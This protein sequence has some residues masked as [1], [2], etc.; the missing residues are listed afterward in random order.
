MKVAP[1]LLH[2]L[3]PQLISKD[4]AHGITITEGY[5]FCERFINSAAPLPIKHLYNTKT[6][7][8]TVIDLHM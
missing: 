3:Q 6:S 7:G 4:V 8:I 2:V 1:V 5:V